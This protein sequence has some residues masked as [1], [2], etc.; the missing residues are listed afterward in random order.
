MK[1]EDEDIQ[2][3]GKPL[4]KAGFKILSSLVFLNR[5]LD[6]F[7]QTVEFELP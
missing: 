5:E 1:T 3:K 4:P 7:I 6:Q 2:I